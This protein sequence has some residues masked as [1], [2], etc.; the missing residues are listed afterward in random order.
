MLKYVD[1]LSLLGIVLGVSAILIGNHLEGGRSFSLVNLSALVIVFG[2]TL[3][4]GLLQTPYAHFK[5]AFKISGWVFKPPQVRSTENIDKLKKWCLMLRQE[6]IRSLELASRSEEDPF[7][8][9]GLQLLVNGVDAESI[10][11]NL[12]T[13]VYL[14][15]ENNR[16]AAKVFES[17]GGYAPTIGILGAVMGLIHVMEDIEHPELLGGGI[18]TAFV[19]TIYGVGLANLVLLPLANKLR[20]I[21]AEIMRSKEMLLEGLVS[22]AS[23]ENEKHM[24][25]QLSVYQQ[26]EY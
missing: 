11:K 9:R 13:Q 1:K 22:I 2:G 21:S 3:G 26:P 24:D 19:S 18:A 12:Q 8:R 5:H 16:K 20:T 10:R 15:E 23:G 4:A 14:E 7:I 25:A 6:G 17:M